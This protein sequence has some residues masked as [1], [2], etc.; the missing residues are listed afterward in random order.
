MGKRYA[1]VSF[2]VAAVPKGMVCGCDPAEEAVNELHG[3]YVNGAHLRARIYVPHARFSYTY[4]YKKGAYFMDKEFPT[5]PESEL[6]SDT[7]SV[8][9]ADTAATAEADP[10]KARKTVPKAKKVEEEKE[11]KTKA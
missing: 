4:H 2:A 7:A 10:A 3:A 5:V 1:V 6:F 8:M 9:T 11:V